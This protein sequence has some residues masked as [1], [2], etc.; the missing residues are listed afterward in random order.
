MKQ[1]IIITFLH[2]TLFIMAQEPVKSKALK[3]RY[4]P[5]SNWSVEEFG[6]KNSWDES[7]NALCHCSGVI[8]TKPNK[9][10]K[11]NVLVYP[12]T[13]SGLDSSKHYSIGNL[14]FEHVEKYDKTKNKHFSFEVRRSNFNDIK[15]KAKSYNVIRY[16]AKVEDHYYIIY[17]WQEN[18]DLLNSTAEKELYE[19]VNAIEPL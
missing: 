6:G 12:S 17:A 4:T 16:L 3:L 19:M 10:G 14:R 1:I 15:T 18:M 9:D 11:M 5:P 2:L 7:G 13:N 8:F